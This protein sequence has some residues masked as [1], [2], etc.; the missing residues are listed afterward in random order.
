MHVVLASLTAP[1]GS[2]CRRETLAV[3]TDLVWAHAVPDD[4]LEHVTPRPTRD[5]IDVYLFVRATGDDDL[6]VWRMRS[7]FDRAGPSIAAQGY[8]LAAR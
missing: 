3:V 4:G 5:G 7:L 1:S 8:V 2:A 6:A